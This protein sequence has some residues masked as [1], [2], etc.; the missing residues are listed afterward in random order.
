MADETFSQ[1]QGMIK[2]I[3]LNAVESSKPVGLFFGTVI[4]TDPLEVQVE[5][6]MTLEADFLII[7]SAVQSLAKSDKV[8]LLR[9]QGGQQYVV[10]DKIRG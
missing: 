5:Q 7:A 2:H 10:L 1:M 3:A 9:V 6:K 4:A 8:I